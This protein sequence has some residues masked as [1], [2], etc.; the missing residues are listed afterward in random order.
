MDQ[1]NLKE[2]T[3]LI[4]EKINAEVSSFSNNFKDELNKIGVLKQ[5]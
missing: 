1:L 3:N 2:I 4:K 5:L